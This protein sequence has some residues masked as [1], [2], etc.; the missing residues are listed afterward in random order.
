MTLKALITAACVAGLG[1]AGCNE[2]Q[3]KAANT[4]LC[5]DFKA[6]K[7][8]APNAAAPPVATDAT[9]AVEDCVRRWAYTL[10]PSG[11]DADAVSEAAVAAC[12]GALARWNQQ[13]VGQ[14]DPAAEALSITTGQPTNPLAEHN[15]FAHAR[16]LL[17]V[18]QARAGHCA[19]PPATGGAPEGAAL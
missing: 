4:G 6:A 11:D 8:P 10:A 7:T 5:Y 17:Y 12:G 19:P 13:T 9:A 16:A 3:M 18:V 15:T 1:L 2:R 14:A